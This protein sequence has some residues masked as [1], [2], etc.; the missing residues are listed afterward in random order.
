MVVTSNEAAHRAASDAEQVAW[1]D[2]EDQLLGTLARSELRERGLI[3]RGTYILLFN[4]A[5]EL[6][7]HRRTLSK[8]IY[9]GYWDVAAGGMVLAVESYA[10]SAARELE[11]ELG[12]S[13]VELTAHD[14]FF[15]EDTDNRLWCSAFSAVWDGPLRLQPEEVLEARFIAIDEVMREITEKPYCPDSLA[16][17]QRYLARRR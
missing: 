6:C 5:G 1:V 10:E 8:A 9:P 14:H 7:V 12:V 2:G 4:S 17:L 11:E 3:G 15:F 16:A 13:G